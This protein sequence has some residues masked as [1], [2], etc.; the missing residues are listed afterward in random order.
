MN[1][2]WEFVLRCNA[3]SPARWDEAA[4]TQQRGDTLLHLL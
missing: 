2:R 4:S 1:T 3:L